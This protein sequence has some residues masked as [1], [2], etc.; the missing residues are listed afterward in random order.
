MAGMNAAAPSPDRFQPRPAEGY[1]GD[2]TPELAFRWWQQGE[3]VLVDVRTDAERDWVGFI[4]GAINIEWKHWPGMLVRPDFDEDLRARVPSD[5]KVVMLCRS[6]VRSVASSR[7]ATE[8]GYEAYN[9]LEGFQGDPDGQ[10][11]RDTVGGWRVRGLP[12]RQG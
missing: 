5:R 2:V 10:G 11:H 4:P 7:R 8:L 6:G 3:A 1:A 12:W 9:I